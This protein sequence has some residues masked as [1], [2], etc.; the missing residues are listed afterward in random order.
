[1]IIPDKRGCPNLGAIPLNNR[2]ITTR[3]VAYILARR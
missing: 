2:Y 1:L 3:L